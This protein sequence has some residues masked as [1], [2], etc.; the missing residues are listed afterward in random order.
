MI[1]VIT[2]SIKSRECPKVIIQRI[3]KGTDVQKQASDR[4]VEGR[5][6]TATRSGGPEPGRS[7]VDP[8]A[9]TSWLAA[10]LTSQGHGLPNGAR[11]MVATGL[12]YTGVGSVRERRPMCW[13]GAASFSVECDQNAGRDEVGQGRTAAD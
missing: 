9:A 7:G 11:G 5:L 6:C 2:L 12:T 3:H 1:A 8:S 10:A 4:D 13:R